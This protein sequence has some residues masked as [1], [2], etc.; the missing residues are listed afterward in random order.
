MT[1][2]VSPSRIFSGSYYLEL[3]GEWSTSVETEV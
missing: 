1:A 2:T 3:G